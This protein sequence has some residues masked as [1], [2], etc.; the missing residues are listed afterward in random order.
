MVLLKCFLFAYLTTN[1]AGKAT[2]EM[3]KNL[4]T[5]GNREKR[6]L[7]YYDDGRVYQD[8][9]HYPVFQN[10]APSRSSQPFQTP[11]QIGAE[12][13]DF[14]GD[15]MRMDALLL[16]GFH[17]IKVLSILGVIFVSVSLLS[18]FNFV[19]GQPL[20]KGMM[21]LLKIENQAAMIPNQPNILDGFSVFSN[22]L[23][24]LKNL[25]KASSFL[26]LV[27]PS[28]N[29]TSFSLGV[30]QGSSSNENYPLSTMS[31][32]E[33]ITTPGVEINFPLLPGVAVGSGIIDLVHQV[34]E[35]IANF[36]EKISNIELVM[37][38]T[39]SPDIAT[40]SKFESPFWLSWVVGEQEADNQDQT[41]TQVPKP[42]MIEGLPSENDLFNQ[43]A[44]N[45][46]PG[47]ENYTSS[48]IEISY[49]L[50]AGA[51]INSGIV[52]LVQKVQE[53]TKNLSEKLSNAEL[54]FVTKVPENTTVS[55]LEGQSWLNWLLGPRRDQNMLNTLLVKESNRSPGIEINY[56]FAADVE[57]NSGI[58]DLIHQVQKGIFNFSHNLPNVGFNLSVNEPPQK[59]ASSKLEGQSWLSWLAGKRG[60]GKQDQTTIQPLKLSWTEWFFPTNDSANP[61]DLNTRPIEQ[62]TTSPGLEIHYPLMADITVN[63][64]IIKK[65][66]QAQGGSS[67]LSESLLNYGFENSISELSETTT[68]STPQI[69][70]WLNWL[71]SK[72]PNKTTT[73][74]PMSWAQWPFTDTKSPDQALKPVDQA[75]IIS[76]LDFKGPLAT[77]L[78]DLQKFTKYDNETTTS[79]N[80]MNLVG[81]LDLVAEALVTQPPPVFQTGSLDIQLKPLVSPDIQLEQSN[82]SIHP[83]FKPENAELLLV[84]DTVIHQNTIDLVNPLD[85]SATL[86]QL[87]LNFQLKPLEA[88]NLQL[89]KGHALVNLDLKP[90]N[91]ETSLDLGIEVPE[92]LPSAVFENV[93]L[94]V[95]QRPHISP[96]IQLQ[97]DNSSISLQ[98]EDGNADLLIN[99]V[100]TPEQNSINLVAPADN[101]EVQTQ[102]D[103][104]LKPFAVPNL[105]LQKDNT[106]INVS[107]KFEVGE[108]ATNSDGQIEFEAATGNPLILNL[109]VSDGLIPDTTDK[110]P[111]Q[112]E[113]S[114]QPL[115]TAPIN[116]AMSNIDPIGIEISKFPN[117]IEALKEP[118]G[119]AAYINR[120]VSKEGVDSNEIAKT[121]SAL[122]SEE[123]FVNRED[124]E[125]GDEE[126]LIGEATRAAWYP[127]ARNLL[128][129]LNKS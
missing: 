22:L 45:T 18:L 6:I 96:D 88:P 29:S 120:L 79:Q 20:I 56:P 75:S 77:F 119:A 125:Q 52:D 76:K 94:N 8:Y 126:N 26:Q 121:I 10:M 42:S 61:N 69:P 1:L 78:L 2:F 36:S 41:V 31:I 38:K 115:A 112:L 24:R 87:E 108:L 58:N 113:I 116:A 15:P 111:A 84:T 49:P 43:N 80:I 33:N 12:R 123:S 19:I 39:E 64:G 101:V 47:K 85:S 30:P 104:Q 98:L 99:T 3:E 9:G 124:K 72:D 117:I 93:G 106:Q 66:Q 68:V 60:E 5:K 128:E 89:Q 44:S 129:A 55:K 95:E 86:G 25:I 37:S 83:E 7:Y 107:A 51:E 35:G 81:P 67:N 82:S 34:Q 32:K 63:S 40:T 50:L 92:T 103:I 74:A 4:E 109:S 105:N 71:V 100:Q 73:Q 16:P 53:G 13:S 17:I 57:I 27:T 11:L 14:T 91:G 46:V 110:N 114:A 23:G 62:N 21:K 122:L 48:G 65:D 54:L 118:K 28:L 59:T 90:G 127:L 70:S 97:Q 102:L